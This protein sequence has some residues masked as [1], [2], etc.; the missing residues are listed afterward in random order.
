MYYPGVQREED[1]G[2]HCSAVQLVVWLCLR[3]ALGTGLF[4][5]SS[6]PFS[7]QKNVLVGVCSLSRKPLM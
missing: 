1:N 6:Y 7:A 2:N 5:Y 4:C 3:W